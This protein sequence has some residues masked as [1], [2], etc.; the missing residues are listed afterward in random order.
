ME[1]KCNRVADRRGAKQR[2][3]RLLLNRPPYKLASLRSGVANGIAR[4][5]GA[6]SR[7]TRGITQCRA[8]LPSKIRD[9]SHRGLG[10]AA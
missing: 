10:G 8:D 9:L 6:T 3:H 5:S 1:E 4:L 7:H 2:P